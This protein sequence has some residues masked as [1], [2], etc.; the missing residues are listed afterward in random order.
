MREYTDGARVVHVLP[1]PTP[2]VQAMLGVYLPSER[3]IIEADL[4]SNTMYRDPPIVE[5]RAR[6]YYEWLR[7]SGLEVDRIARVH[8]SVVP[9]R[10]FA[11][12]VEGAR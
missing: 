6:E 2:H 3:L 12:I 5:P 7:Q 10:E 1:V 9:F 11:S 8:G 4:V